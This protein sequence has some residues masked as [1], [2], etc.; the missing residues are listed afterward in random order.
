MGETLALIEE[1]YSQTHFCRGAP[2]TFLNE[3]TVEGKK[4][5]VPSRSLS[6]SLTR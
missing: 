1:P 3:I 4:L 6:F 5:K 2:E